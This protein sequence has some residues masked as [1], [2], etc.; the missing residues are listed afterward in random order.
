MNIFEGLQASLTITHPVVT[1]GNFDGVH[2]GHQ[3]IIH[4]LNQEAKKNGGESVLFTF[5]PHPRLVL[6]PGDTSLKLL[7]TQVEKTKKL[8]EFG[9]QN[10]IVYPFSKEFSQL[11]AQEFVRDI[12]V[13]KIGV[14]TLV[15]GYD[16]HFGKNREGGLDFLRSVSE[17]YG[18][19]VIEISAQEI[20]DI[21]VSSTKIRLAIDAGEVDLVKDYLSDYFEINGTVIEGEQIGRELGFPTANLDLKNPNK[22]IPK[23]GVYAV[24]VTIATGEMINGMMNIGS[25]PTIDVERKLQLEVHLL[26]FQGD[27]YGTELTVRFH[28]FVREEIAFDSKEELIQQIKKDGETVRNYFF[29]HSK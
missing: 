4:R 19:D 23:N 18:F 3:K 17:K 21:N 14:K 13:E 25:R 12:L 11:N 28:T 15:I 20:N 7:Q 5:H 26:D 10:L 24:D 16:H 2:V 1:I 29:I 27:L 9:L 22:L 8:K 6:N